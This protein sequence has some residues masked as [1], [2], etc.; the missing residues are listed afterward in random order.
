MSAMKIKRIVAPDMRQALKEVSRQLG[1]EAVVLSSRALPEGGV[2]VL[3]GEQGQPQP[4][5][6]RNP[7]T[8][9]LDVL[10]DQ[11]LNLE[12]GKALRDRLKGLDEQQG[13]RHRGADTI[14]GKGPARQKTATPTG[15][16]GSSREFGE[17]RSE[18][19]TIR[20]LLQ[21][22]LAGLAW[23]QFSQR[24]PVQ[25]SIWEK[26]GNMG[27]PGYLSK[28]LLDRLKPEYTAS[29]AWRF[30][31]AYLN[32]AVPVRSD[33]PIASGGI[34]ALL[35][36]TGV[37]KTTTIGKL[38]TRYVLQHGA[39]A[40]ALVTTD[41]Y[42]IAAHEQ[43]RTLGRI[44]GVTVRV[45][46]QHHGL[47]ETLESLSYK[48]LILID[49][50]G[51]NPADP[52]MKTQL[53]SLRD[54][55][56]VQKLLVMSCTSQGRVL[57]KAWRDYSPAN[58]NGCVLSKLDE[59]GTL[60]EALALVID[61][62]LPVMYETHGQSIPDDIG[63]AQAHRL[64]SRAVALGLPEEDY[65]RAGEDERRSDAFGLAWAGSLPGSASMPLIP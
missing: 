5:A 6:S 62:C 10:K 38:A 31:L 56:Q 48:S 26:L 41:S 22:R 57:G 13:G 14:A 55:P 7:D 64:V 45:V 37:G 4:Q 34:F 11:Q 63:V 30:T 24:T 15:P 46:D 36:P 42:R 44:L 60:G 12:G 2:E 17:M 27:L 59:A 23:E 47:T 19:N 43:L 49:T 54:E 61:R 52:A 1:L 32:R 39:D 51:L 18:L 28:D 9:F 53:D 3:A 50:A 25:A 58:L 65:Q 8:P 40:V 20:S 35:G 33:D 21:Q 29:Q 16:D